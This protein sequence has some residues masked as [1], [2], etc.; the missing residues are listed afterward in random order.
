MSRGVVLLTLGL[1]LIATGLIQGA[2]L[3]PTIWLGI[4][5][6]ALGIA[7]IKG[8]HAI[9]GKRTDGSLPLWSWIVFLPLLLYTSAVWH[10]SR[11]ITREPA[12]NKLADDLVLARRLLPREPEGE[13]VNYIDLTA[14][15]QEPLAIRRLPGYRCF[16]ILD[17]GAPDPKAL[18]KILSGLRPGRTLIHCA[19]GHGR[20][21][22]FTLALMLKSGAATSVTEGLEKLQSVRP[23]INLSNAQRKCIE[24]FTAELAKH[25]KP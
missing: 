19:Q 21:G 1:A 8:A 18:R 11:L 17:G 24:Q 12:Q 13:F 23:R 7:H 5:F 20:T 16:P 3:F 9:F 25:R 6:V 10:I 2:W 4:D 14:E 22:M 15:F